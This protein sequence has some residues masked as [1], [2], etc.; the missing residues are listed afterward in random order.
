MAATA[1]ILGFGLTSL[2]MTA[3]F[4]AAEDPLSQGFVNPPDEV[5]PAIYGDPMP[6]GPIPEAVITRDLE[7]MKAKG[8]SMC[9]LYTPERNAERV[10]RGKKLIYG[11]TA[12]QVVKTDE[13]DGAGVLKVELPWSTVSWSPD[14]VKSVRWAAREAGRIGIELGVCVGSASCE[15][16]MLPDGKKDSPDRLEYGEQ[17]LIHASTAVEAG[18]AVD[19]LIP[20]PRVNIRKKSQLFPSG[21]LGPVSIQSVNKEKMEYERK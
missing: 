13:Y 10:Y 14:W 15:L 19:V 21:L 8:I 9:L 3:A 11:E 4:G 12:H 20:R 16:F 2:W 18:A 5:R 1:L 7:E 6:G 17:V